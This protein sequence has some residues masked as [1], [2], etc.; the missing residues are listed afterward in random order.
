VTLNKS[1]NK[2]KLTK[3]GI[4]VSLTKVDISKAYHYSKIACEDK[5][6]PKQLKMEF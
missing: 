1:G 3:D 5:E 6:H 2:I 4:T